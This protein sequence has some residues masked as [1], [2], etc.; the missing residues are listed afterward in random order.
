MSTNDSNSDDSLPDLSCHDGKS[1]GNRA[2]EGSNKERKQIGP[3][4]ILQKIAA[5]GMGEV[6]MAE[7]E[8]PVRRR[9]AIKV[10]KS[11]TDSEQVI[12]RFEAERQ[13]IAMMN[14]PNIAKV[15]DVGATDGG[16]P[17][18]AMEL[19]KGV[20]LT[21]Y[22]DGNK[23]PVKERLNLFIP[24]CRAIQHAHQKGVIHRD[25]KP[26]N[27]LVA[28]YDGR[29]VPKV[30]DFGLAKATEHQMRLTDKTMFTEYGQIVGTLQYMSPEQAQMNQLDVDTRTDIYSL[31]VMLYELLTG[32]P[33]LDQ[34][35]MSQQALL[36]VL[37]LIREVD[38]PRP[39]TR[40]STASKNATVVSSARKIQPVRLQQI[41]KGDLDWIV[42]KALEKDRRRRYETAAALA[43]DVARHLADQ[44][45]LARPPSKSYRI[46]KFVR[47]NRGLVTSMLAIAFLLV[48]GIVST[49]IGLF[50]AQVAEKVAID[51]REIANEEKLQAKEAETKARDSKEEANR[52]KRVAELELTKSNFNLAGAR[53]E[54]GRAGEARQALNDIPESFRAIEWQLANHQFRAND[55]TCHGHAGSVN[56][57]AIS[58]DGKCILSGSSDSKI[59]IWD[60]VSGEE[61]RS[62]DAHGKSVRAIDVSPNGLFFVSGSIDGTVS[63][64]ERSSGNELRKL[65]GHEGAINDVKF[66]PDGSRIATCG[67]DKTIRLWNTKSGDLEGVLEGHVKKIQTLGFSIDGSQLFSGSGDPHSIDDKGLLRKW[68]LKKMKQVDIFNETPETILCLDVSPDGTRVVSVGGDPFDKGLKGQ[69]K[70]WDSASGELV[71]MLDGHSNRVTSVAFSPDGS[72]VATGS[73]DRSIKL[74]DAKTGTLAAEFKGSATAINALA[75]SGSCRRLISGNGSGSDPGEIHVRDVDAR[76]PQITLRRNGHAFH[77]VAY[78]SNDHELLSGGACGVHL[79]DCETGELLREYFR[80]SMFTDSGGVDQ[81]AQCVAIS[82]DE[83]IV[84]AGLRDTTTRLWDSRTGNLIQTLEGHKLP[85]LGIFFSPDGK[86]IATCSGEYPNPARIIMWHVESGEKLFSIDAHPSNINGIAFHPDGKCFASASEDRTIK[87]WNSETG[88]LVRTLKGHIGFVHCVD[89]NSDGSLL[90]SGGGNTVRLWNP[91]TGV[92]IANLPGHTGYI[93]SVRFSPDGKRLISGSYDRTARLWNLETYDEVFSLMHDLL[94]YDAI[95]RGDQLQVATASGDGTVRLWNASSKQE[96][97]ILEGHSSSITS[98]E[99]DEDNGHFV[100]RS[101]VEEITWNPDQA[102]PR[103]NQKPVRKTDSK[104]PSRENFRIDSSDGKWLAISSGKKLYLVDLLFKETL[105]ERTFRIAKSKPDVAW[106]QVKALEA[107]KAGDAYASVFHLA[108]STNT[109]N[110]PADDSVAARLAVALEQLE[111]ENPN[112]LE[113]MF[114]PKVHATIKLQVSKSNPLER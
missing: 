14:H 112:D 47:K 11:G 106:H 85:V 21:Q 71:M 111:K 31:G 82:P 51:Q 72:M 16:S 107:E 64:W 67:Q 45:V 109:E 91:E 62:L 9:V 46:K 35:T 114:A 100:T 12:A 1:V 33:P 77:S 70:I 61:L 60:I 59:K 32:S 8:K 15:L 44:P 98:L 63:V 4:K 29:P 93:T 20:P 25:L 65:L 110:E 10:I 69:I 89:F 81:L 24:V 104:A 102:D 113:L 19:V 88:D 40:L 26:S 55:V 84:G 53:W 75:F 39:S 105:R 103:V 34:D 101:A 95:F 7:Q 80:N 79:W 76:A 99:Y 78:K 96:R 42:M 38:P 73:W 92:E 17:F 5:G 23:L 43:D 90:A 41:L 30:I 13:A 22:C 6:Y 68:D 50:R 83:T 56:A 27:V 86:Q 18:F 94:V 57:V 49:S 3:Y 48:A 108:M 58:P 97:R 54:Q 52:L 74:W 2:H 36:Q 87:I 37:Q 28:L 66:S